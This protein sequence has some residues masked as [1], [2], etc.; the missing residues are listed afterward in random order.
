M[1]SSGAECTT[2]TEGSNKNQ[3]STSI[4]EY[5]PPGNFHQDCTGLIG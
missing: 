5:L 2:P 3:K 1:L 4:Y